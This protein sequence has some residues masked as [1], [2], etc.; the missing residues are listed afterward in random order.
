MGWYTELFYYF[1]LFIRGPCWYLWQEHS[2]FQ[3]S[4]HFSTSSCRHSSG[5]TGEYYQRIIKHCYFT[6]KEYMLGIENIEIGKQKKYAEF[7]MFLLA[8]SQI[9]LTHHS[10][11]EQ[12]FLNEYKWIQRL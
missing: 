3:A 9:L 2:P 5:C 7:N 10:I 1:V 6:R 4:S 11:Y 8:V 12:S